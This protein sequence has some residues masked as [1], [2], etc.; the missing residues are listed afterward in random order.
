MHKNYNVTFR[1]SILL[2]I[3][4]FF[5]SRTVPAQTLP[6]LPIDTSIEMGT[7]GCGASYYTVT[8]PLR[9]GYA[10]IALVQK[11]DSLTQRKRDALSADFLARMGVAPCEHGYLQAREQSTVYFFKDVPFYR[12]EVLDSMLLY[13]FWQ[14]ARVRGP[15][16]VVVSGDVDAVELKKKMEVFSLLVSRLEKPAPAGAFHWESD[17]V[18]VLDARTAP[19]SEV[20]V[21]YSGNRIP[22]IFMNTAQALVT[23]IFGLE[24]LVLL[25]H[26]LEADLTAAGIVHGDISF[27]SL[28]SA[29]YSGPERYTVKV[30]VAPGAE[31]AALEQMAR[32]LA[33]MDVE[34]VSVEEF[35]EAKDVLRPAIYRQ[36]SV[37]KDWIEPCINH[38]LYGANLAPERERIR[39][40]TR[41]N[42]P[43]E[44]ETR[45][46]NK[47]ASALLSGEENLG[48]SLCAP[49]TLDPA[50]GL[51]HYLLHYRN[52]AAVPAGKTYS[53]HR[54]DS[55]GLECYPARVR[56]KK[57][58]AEPVS[59][60]T[61]WTFSNG[62]RVVY[63]R[64]SG[65]GMF[66]Y[67][68]VLNGGLS[69]IPSLVEG[70]GG[71]IGPML[72]LYDAS[73][74]PAPAF[75][76][77]LEA[78]GLTMETRVA[79]SAMTIS[80]DAPKGKFPFLLK[81]LLALSNGREPNP[82]EFERYRDRAALEQPSVEDMLYGNMYPDFR[83]SA[84]KGALTTATPQKAEAY[85]AERFARMNDGVLILSGDLDEGVV[86]KV[87][88]RYLGGFRTMRGTASRRSVEL[89]PRAGS[90]T[91]SGTQGAP[92]IYMLLDA[93]QSL[94]TD[95]CY[96]AQVAA[97]ALRSTLARRLTPY[98]YAVKV[99]VRFMAQP[100]ERIQLLVSATPV[101]PSALP[102][103]TPAQDSERVL[104]VVRAAMAEAARQPVPPEDLQAWKQELAARVKAVLSTSAGFTA[105]L[106]TRYALNKDVT[107]RSQESIQAVSAG[108]VNSFLSAMAGG[109]VIEYVV[110]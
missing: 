105:T 71:H 31:E 35:S 2:F 53:W 110:K 73:G 7:L 56:I 77:M 97:Q 3:A 65:T 94:T 27:D 51:F 69:Q 26:R 39:L 45:L 82:A 15:Q 1:K 93:A 5:F 95:N 40:F 33:A 30:K 42:I 104:T 72:S 80:G 85:F 84:R 10:S 37:Q 74:L 66:H 83:Y 63:K 98:G 109:G 49:D 25:R 76:D 108:R 78:N 62:M 14:M 20:A 38:F 106:T 64:V 29:D 90:V 32:T 58:K 67:A 107:T 9:K 17:P 89:R 11:A 41:K 43:E 44:T 13:T 50:E 68:L 28:R 23:D 61:L 8:A 88:C 79:L 22:A 75:R 87:L 86:K 60:G 46:F 36:A 100:Q 47:Y 103:G 52:A 57:E 21:S 16:A 101:P 55:A 4:A 91:L 59:G 102:S 70:E 19:V 6:P 18:P 54:A 48:L 24:F 12:P 99:E 96:T 92:G 81:V 34:G